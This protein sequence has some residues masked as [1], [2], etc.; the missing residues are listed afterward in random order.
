[1][2]ANLFL[3]RKYWQC[4]KF[5][6]VKIIT[7]IMFLTALVTT[8]LLIERTELRREL[9]DI[10]FRNG[11]GSMVYGGNLNGGRFIRDKLISDEQLEILRED[12]RVE[13]VGKAAI[14]GKIGDER[15]QYT[16]GAYYD[17]NARELEN[18]ELL[19]GRFPESSGEAAIHDYIAENLFFEFEPQNALGR[20]ITLDLFDFDGNTNKTGAKVGEL[21]IK[22]VGVIKS[23]ANPG[24]P[25]KE[26]YQ[27]F[28]DGG[29]ELSTPVVYLY[30]G[31]V[32]LS[33]NSQ[34]YAY[35]EYAGADV[36][37]EEFYEE[38]GAF[39]REMLENGLMIGQNME[40]QSVSSLVN[41]AYQS[42]DISTKIYPSDTTTAIR[43]FSLLAIVIS[44]IALFGV[45]YPIIT[46]REKSL[47]TMRNL[48]ASK[49][50]KYLILFM[51][52]LIFLTVGVLVGFVL[53]A[54]VYELILALQK[55]LL[56]LPA[57]RA[58]SAEWGVEKIS[59]NPFVTAVICSAAVLALGYLIYFASHIKRGAKTPK[60]N[61]KP[62][63]LGL[64]LGR[65]SGTFF[66][67]FTHALL[68]AAVI[69][70]CTF[71]YCY[72]TTNGKG[73]SRWFRSEE[74]NGD[75]FF[76]VGNLDLREIGA[77]AVI[78]SLNSGAGSIRVDRNTG[79]TPDEARQLGEIPGITD[80]QCFARSEGFTLVYPQ[81]SENIPAPLLGTELEWY[82]GAEQVLPIFDYYYYETVA[83][84]LNDA[85]ISSL[86]D[87]VT[88]GE[89]GQYKNGVAEI[90]FEGKAPSFSVGEALQT[91]S[92]DNQYTADVDIFEREA[93]VEAIVTLPESARESHPAMYELLGDLD[94][95]NIRFAAP[96]ANTE[97]ISPL[98]SNYDYTV[99]KYAENADAS[100]VFSQIK[101]TVLSDQAMII[102]TLAGARKSYSENLAAHFAS[103]I[104]I[105]AVIFLMMTAGFYAIIQTRLES[106]GKNFATLRALGMSRKAH[107]RL[108]ALHTLRNTVFGCIGG[109]ALSYAAKWLLRL[110]EQK[111]LQMLGGGDGGY[112]DL[113]LDELQRAF[114]NNSE[115]YLLLDY[116]MQYVPIIGF[117]LLLSGI[118][119]LLSA[120][121]AFAVFS[122]TDKETI[123]EQINEKERS[124]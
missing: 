68:V 39:M 122:K 89:I 46:E 52:A 62:R 5:Q 14:L 83:F 35:I 103:I 76:A 49:R 55:S 48:G 4:H 26:Y 7:A 117:L 74:F 98:K 110:R 79:I 20:E 11:L 82:E 116:E 100:R 29:A 94:V 84:F 69:F 17:E 71:G 105:I 73:S 37:T 15:R 23:S 101:Q 42:S 50:R 107:K 87:Y 86:K 54:G 112:S 93:I 106:A 18:L 10:Q 108:F 85:V 104:S 66:A 9:R 57:L 75:S 109:A 118:L 63:S 64:L 121:F 33:E 91:I 41:F 28:N 22:I 3:I 2:K 113:G 92:I 102:S 38:H 90:I 43:Y 32:P 8:S 115:H 6:F 59:E 12:E 60:K 13:R 97:F 30:H 72:S 25:D 124:L 31:D 56:G 120:A 119:L 44:S 77:D 61:A 123:M 34:T 16:C 81:A 1:M 51:E 78:Y 111:C 80:V 47:E 27:F 70:T 53:S 96:Q 58:Y 21:T 95:R 19:A 36:Y 114:I 67:N 88:E 65:V 99:V 40:A 45:L 24:R